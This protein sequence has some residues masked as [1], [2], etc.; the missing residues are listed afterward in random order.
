MKSFPLSI[1]SVWFGVALL[2]AA[3][4]SSHAHLLPA[5]IE[6]LTSVEG[7][8]EYRL[9]NGLSV[10]LFP[11]NS[12]PLATVDLVFKVGSRQEGYGEK[13]MAH[14]LEH[15]NFKGT[16][17]HTNIPQ[18]LS[19][20]GA[21][22]NA[23]TWLD[24]TQYF[25]TFDATEANLRWA[26]E[27]EADRM[28]HSHIWKKDLDTEFSVVRN[29]YEMGENDPGNVLN[30]RMMP[31][32]F[33]WHN[34]GRDTIGEKSDI[35]GAPIE[36]L[37]AFYH[38]YYQPDNAVLIVSGKIDEQQTLGMIAEYY[39]P[40]PKP[41][42][43]LIPTYTREPVQD[44]EREITLRRTGDIQLVSAMYRA[45][46]SSHE[47][48]AAL[49]VLADLLTDAPSGR[50]YKALVESK[51]A[52]SVDG[53]MLGLAEAGVLTFTARLRQEQSIDGVRGILLGIL[54][55]MKT[56][57]PTAEEVEKSKTRQLK[58][59]ENS[60][61][62][63]SAFTG[64]LAEGVASGDWRL[65]FVQRD[66][67]EKMTPDLV[68]RAAEYYLK[69]ANRTLGIFIP[70]KVS[71]RVEIPNAPDL[72]VL[73]RDYKG[74]P[75]VA[76]GE[77]F[78]ATPDNIEKR[79]MRGVLPNGMK[80]A[81]LPKQTRGGV[82]NANLTFRF[83]TLETLLGKSAVGDMTASLLDKGSRS[84]SRQEIHDAFDKLKAEVSFSG[85]KD[86]LDVNIVSDKE[87]IADV[88]RLAAEVV[89]QPAFPAHEFDILKRDR[90]ASFEEQKSNPQALAYIAFRRATS[91]PFS[92]D[93][94][95]YPMNLEE[96]AAAF[97]SVTVDQVAEFYQG[98]YGASSATAGFVG[99][100]DPKDV[101]AL[102]REAFGDW[103]NRVPFQ[104]IA[105]DYQF[106]PVRSET[107]P[108]PDKANAV[109]FA[110]LS[111]PM[112]QD[113]DQYPAL[114]M[115]GRIIGGG[116][117]NS[118]LARRIRQKEGLS[119]GVE[120]FFNADALD[121]LGSFTSGMIF[122]PQNVRKLEV[123]FREEIEKASKDGFTEDELQQAKS[124]W[125]QGQK[126]NRSSDGSLAA[127][128]N[129]YLYLGRNL[130][131]DAKLEDKVQSLTTTEVKTTVGKYLDFSKLT[132]VKAGDF[133]P[134]PEAR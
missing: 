63:S 22:A 127:T 82:V 128:L 122:N 62:D 34:Y 52:V 50:L 55:N 66:Y 98:F 60:F 94:P 44:G 35:E 101:E 59:F 104:R 25:E 130:T 87:H 9:T 79:T 133:K 95:R 132:S 131:W 28:I 121:E 91:P 109:Y 96:S 73:L 29:E 74:K 99:D 65:V 4:L 93:D 84:K 20:R 85:S 107:I 112:K 12:K 39:G 103:K 113:D 16:D 86:S 15:L 46:P 7:I 27:L 123:A 83:G 14:L 126:V 41:A 3:A 21:R 1:Q 120:A 37:Q 134:A 36:R 80:Y 61:K 90:L 42:R 23:N 116:I 125:L 115:G 2:F 31:T 64:R 67:L 71:D 49:T 111:F 5:G 114:L 10:L 81:F 97:E 89:R 30:K 88:L 47:D 19:E 117:L 118:R 77:N 58:D 13:G 57:P 106:V 17:E 105:N 33:Q 124:G 53:S 8:T 56:N 51:K 6:K 68:S 18:E 78:D 32:V 38:Y 110:G 102:L 72:A 70:E 129:L 76:A 40:I 108:T 11:D 45:A 100:F 75:E 119:Y 69:P 43:Q 24:R 54:E 48:A 92:K 26:L